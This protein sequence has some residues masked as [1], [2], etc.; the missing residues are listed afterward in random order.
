MKKR[1]IL[2]LLVALVVLAAL[3]LTFV[4]CDPDGQDKIDYS[5]T[6]KLPDGSPAQGINAAFAEI[7]DGTEGEPTLVATNELGVATYTSEEGNPVKVTLAGLDS[8]YAAPAPVQLSAQQ[9]SA[10]I[11]LEDAAALPSAPDLDYKQPISGRGTA[12]YTDSTNHQLNSSSFKPYVLELGNYKFKFDE[13]D[14]LI[15][16]QI[17]LGTKDY[18]VYNIYSSGGVD[19]AIQTIVGN[20]AGA[21]Y[22]AT[23][24]GTDN[25]DRPYYNDN[26]DENSV[27]F[28]LEFSNN[29]S[30]TQKQEVN[31]VT[32]FELSLQNPA[33][34]GYEFAVTIEKL[35][36]PYVPKPPI[37]WEDIHASQPIAPATEGQGALHTIPLNASDFVVVRAQDGTYRLGGQDGPQLYAMVG[38]SNPWPWGVTGEGDMPL[39]WSIRNSYGNLNQWSFDGI[40]GEN[41]QP[42]LVEYA[43]NANSDGYYPVNDELKEFLK[44]VAAD[45]NTR[46]TYFNADNLANVSWSLP[47]GEEWI[48]LCGY[49][50]EEYTGPDFNGNGTAD[51]PYTLL[52]AGT[53]TVNVPAGGKVYFATRVPYDI[54][55]TTPNAILAYTRGGV[56]EGTTLYGE[57]GNGFSAS[58]TPPEIAYSPEFF[59]IYLK[60]GAAGEV[61]FTVRNALY[62]SGTSD[63]PYQLE[64]IVGDFSH[65]AGADGVWYSVYLNIKAKYTLSTT[66]VGL[67]FAIFDLD[68]E[69]ILTWTST[70]AE[71]TKEFT[72]DSTEYHIKVSAASE[73]ELSWAIA[74]TERITEQ[75]I[76]FGGVDE[77]S[78]PEMGIAALTGTHK[79]EL[80]SNGGGT[81]PQVWKFVGPTEGTTIVIAPANGLNVSV[82]F[83]DNAAIMHTLYSSTDA[84][85]S[86]GGVQSRVITLPLVPGYV[87]YLTAESNLSGVYELEIST[88]AGG[89]TEIGAEEG[90]QAN[91]IEIDIAQLLVLTSVQAAGGKY[92]KL[93]VEQDVTL[94]LTC[95]TPGAVI[96]FEAIDK[97]EYEDFYSLNAEDEAGDLTNFTLHAGVEYTITFN[98]DG[99]GTQLTIAVTRTNA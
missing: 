16:I 89:G 40:T 29:E 68:D 79:I 14:Q 3:T 86:W 19:A 87:Y 44:K 42:L 58:I 35:D 10:T 26:K 34:V 24:T 52:K 15:Y 53:F 25:D 55:S 51:T 57:D 50:G 39:T 90:S 61:T 63:D 46:A 17:N 41:W 28:E 31:G 99:E 92:Y 73:Q 72:L 69:E 20:T 96:T 75:D 95:E 4:A 81:I 23:K 47:S 65:S 85:E 6:V 71:K 7:K 1:H 21:L 18:G 12:R 30:T 37:Q 66:C 83:Y 8:R 97:E 48:F 38:L 59:Q 64:D 93:A 32:Y 49:Y 27:D 2:T 78:A 60:D 91:P 84:T 43:E 45:M 9:K 13:A 62:G 11:T 56:F 22:N 70:D 5:V 67:N 98:I 82:S 88:R 94:T 76:T 74:L 33:H 36:K 80:S 54:S 77:D